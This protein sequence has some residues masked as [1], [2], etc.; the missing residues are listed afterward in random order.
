LKKVL[1]VVLATGNTLNEGS[2]NGN[3]RGFQIQVRL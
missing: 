1:A 2:F 3:A